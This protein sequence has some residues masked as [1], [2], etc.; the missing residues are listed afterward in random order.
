MS[1]SGSETGDDD[2]DDNDDD[3]DS[4]E[5]ELEAEELEALE[6]ALEAARRWKNQSEESERRRAREVAIAREQASDLRKTIEKLR[7]EANESKEYQPGLHMLPKIS[8]SLQSTMAD[9][10]ILPRPN[11]MSSRTP[12]PRSQK[13]R[14]YTKHT[15]ESLLPS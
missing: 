6:E 8:T 4:E 12:D 10:G 9:S 11:D 3:D 15:L 7:R 5:L 1:N 13:A 14:E 2:D